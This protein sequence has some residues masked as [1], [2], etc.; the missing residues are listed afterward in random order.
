MDGDDRHD[1]IQRIAKLVLQ[2]KAVDDYEQQLFDS[3]NELPHMFPTAGHEIAQAMV[4]VNI[5]CQDD[6]VF[7]YYR[8]KCLWFAA[9]LSLDEYAAS[10]RQLPSSY[11]A[12]K[13]LSVLPYKRSNTGPTIAPV[14]GGVGSQ[15]EPALGWARALKLR[16][17]TDL[18]QSNGLAFAF[19][20]DGAV[21]TGGFWSAVRESSASQ[22]P[23]VI[24]IENNGIAIS[25]RSKFQFAGESVAKLFAAFPGLTVHSFD[26]SLPQNE[27][28]ISEL[29]QKARADRRPIL[30]E[31][32]VERLTRHSGATREQ[33]DTPTAKERPD[34]ECLRETADSLQVPWEE[35][36]DEIS[37]ATNDAFSKEVLPPS[38][39]LTESKQASPA[40]NKIFNLLHP[41]GKN[42]VSLGHAIRVWLHNLMAHHHSSVVLGEDVGEMGGIHGITQGLTKKFGEDR[43]IDT[44]LNEGAILG[45]ALGMAYQGLLPVAEIQFRKYLEPAMEQFHNI[46]WCEWL[47]GRAFRPPIIIRIPYGRAQ[48]TD[49]WHSESDESTVLRA[50]GYDVASPCTARDAIN[51]LDTAYCSG[52]P[53]VVLEHREM[54][55]DASS[56]TVLPH[57]RDSPQPIRANLVSA[58]ENATIVCWGNTVK[59]VLAATSQM[60]D[61][62]FDVIDLCWLRPWDVEAVTGSVRKTG[63]C[64]VVHE[65]R[66]FL[67]FGAE[68]SATISETCWDDLKS[69]VLRLG[70]TENPVPV[71]AELA[72]RTLP[73][74]SK[75]SQSIRQLLR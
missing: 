22:L 69:T 6:G 36:K 65:D 66:T 64:L 73:S 12:G 30:I 62:N 46:G 15:L 2:T 1:K 52:R 61:F 24:I 50:I 70:A 55:Y 7:S 37:K 11:S 44:A 43:V 19:A 38:Q 48:K 58:G 33:S 18:S 20:G 57:E 56:R 68:I 16:R 13:N 42:K 8:S 49:P 4:G 54:Y 71:S 35:L 53:T 10:A 45:Q 75:I 67:G 3:G 32:F 59:L 27:E 51:V 47:T 21:A 9:G 14:F 34:L 17:Q 29:I 72:E 31:L 26:G 60:E 63:R 25:T 5:D 28:T 74:V 23:I 40:S 41:Y 39:F